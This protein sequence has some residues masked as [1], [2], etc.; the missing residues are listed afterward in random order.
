MY[1]A[2]IG[3]LGILAHPA[4]TNQACCAILQNE[5]LFGYV[6]IYSYLLENRKKIINLGQGAAQQN[7]NQII[8]KNLEMLKPPEKIMMQ[9][10]GLTNPLFE[11]MKVLQSKNYILQYSRDLLLPRLVSGE[12]DVSEMEINTGENGHE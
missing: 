3:K 1:G 8:I 12:L 5:D 4:T 2:T 9:F 11:L 10:N 6:Y 7:I